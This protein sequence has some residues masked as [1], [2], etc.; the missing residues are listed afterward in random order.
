VHDGVN[1]VALYAR[2]EDKVA[3]ISARYTNVFAHMLQYRPVDLIVNTLPESARNNEA[4]V[5]QGVTPDTIAVDVTYAP[6][7]STWRAMYQEAGCRT[8]NGLG[9]LAFQAALQMSWWFDVPIDP[10]HLLGVIS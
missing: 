3:N 8:Q 2:S 4:A 10:V 5:I 9:M 1:S 6:A 7:L